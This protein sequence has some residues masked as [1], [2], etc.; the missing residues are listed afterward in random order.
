VRSGTE[1]EA[2]MRDE[3]TPDAEDLDRTD[4]STYTG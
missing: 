2:M 3:M 4:D 1:Q